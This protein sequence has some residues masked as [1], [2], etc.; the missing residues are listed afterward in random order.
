MRRNGNNGKNVFH[1]E[2]L[3][4]ETIYIRKYLQIFGSY[5]FTIDG[6]FYTLNGKVSGAPHKLSFQPLGKYVWEFLAS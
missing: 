2:K 1:V 5:F 6:L 3:Y 4:K